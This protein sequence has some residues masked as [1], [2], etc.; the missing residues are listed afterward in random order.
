MKWEGTKSFSILLNQLDARSRRERWL[1][2]VVGLVF[3]WIIFDFALFQPQKRSVQAVKDKIESFKRQT[4]DLESQVTQLQSAQ[5]KNTTVDIQ[6]KKVELERKLSQLNQQLKEISE[7]VVSPQSMANLLEQIL[8]QHKGLRLVKIQNLP[9][10][11]LSDQF[12]MHPLTIVFE[13]GYFE[14]LTYLE[15]IEKLYHWRFF[16]DALEYEVI[17][18]PKAMVTLKLHTISEQASW[19]G[20]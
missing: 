12:F 17:T 15:K 5:R 10:K 1:V 18:Y 11:P 20:I 7:N 2:V 14:T 9:A 16:W 13:G 4:T 6:Q 8:L 3:I 19:L